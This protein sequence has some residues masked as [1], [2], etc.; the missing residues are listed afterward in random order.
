MRPTVRSANARFTIKKL[1]D[2]RSSLFGSRKTA[3]QTSRLP[4]DVI[5]EKPAEMAAVEKDNS[6]GASTPVQF[7]WSADMT[8]Y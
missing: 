4:G 7:C 3:K 5:K 2:V 6:F 1:N 8:K